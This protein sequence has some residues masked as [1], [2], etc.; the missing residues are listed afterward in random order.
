MNRKYELL[1]PKEEISPSQNQYRLELLVSEENK[2]EIVDFSAVGGCGWPREDVGIRELEQT[3]QDVQLVQTQPKCTD[4]VK[5]TFTS[6]LDS[7]G[8]PP[9]R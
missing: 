5:K 3:I 8:L 6:L 4:K 2:L 1:I 9:G 7:G